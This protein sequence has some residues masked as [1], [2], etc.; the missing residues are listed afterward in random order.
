MR[1][2]PPQIEAESIMTFKLNLSA[3]VFFLQGRV[4]PQVQE[5]AVML[6]LI[7]LLPFS[8]AQAQQLGPS[9]QGV[10]PTGVVTTG[11]YYQ[12]YVLEQDRHIE[13]ISFPIHVAVPVGPSTSVSLRTSPASARGRGLESITGLSDA[14][15]MVSHGGRIGGSSFVLTLG[16]N[17]PSGKRALTPDEFETTVQLSRN[18]YD[19]RTPAFGQGLNASP[20]VTWAVPLGEQIVL[21]LGAAY[22]YKGGFKPLDGMDDS[23]R[24]GSEVLL[25]GG[26]DVR[27]GPAAALSGDVTYTRYGTDTIGSAEVFDAAAQLTTTLQLLM[28]RGFDE[29]RVLG[30]YRD[31]GRGNLLAPG[32]DPAPAMQTLP[33]QVD[34][35][36]SYRLRT[37][38]STS[39]GFHSGIHYF[40][41]T[42][43]FPSRVLL[44]LGVAPERSLSDEISLWTRF[45]S[46][47]GDFVGLE[48]GAGLTVEI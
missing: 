39:I 4:L 33:N 48:V 9:T 20:G 42:D 30:R 36:G 43:V 29:L 40:D 2:T 32:A 45:S 47:L 6:L 13:E 22:Q 25:T 21:G 19:F 16:V 37:A 44:S 7:M 31:R 11:V 24:P 23:Y 14:Q 17:L 10:R 34:I 18:M 41:E 8:T 1:Q 3:I 5:F 26:L 15:F 27:V 38:A 46:R 35:F 12:R 28:Y